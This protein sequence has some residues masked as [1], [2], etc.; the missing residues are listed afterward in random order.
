M[1]Y[2]RVKMIGEV[3]IEIF[4]KK[5]YLQAMEILK[6]GNKKKADR[7]LKKARKKQFKENQLGT[8]LRK[9]TG[10]VIKNKLTG[11]WTSDPI[12]RKNLITTK[13]KEIMIKQLIGTTTTPIVGIA[14]GTGTVAPTAADTALGT[15]Y[16]RAAAVT[17]ITTTTTT[18]DSVVFSKSFEFTEAVSITEEGLFDHATTGGNL[19]AR[20]TFSSYDVDDQDILTITHKIRITV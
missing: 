2:S 12:V 14:I 20:H 5:L 15:E 11:K 6:G 19:F 1:L 8:F 16:D 4:D 7:V 3:G 10:K 18:N 13:G 9:R 17:N